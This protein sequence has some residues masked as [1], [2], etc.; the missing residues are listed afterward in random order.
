[1]LGT[2][3]TSKSSTLDSV[4][5][6]SLNPRA[7]GQ[8]Q[9]PP[10]GMEF[11]I[12]RSALVEASAARLGRLALPGRRPIDTPNFFAATS[13]GVVPHLTPDNLV[14]HDDLVR[15][16]Y[17]AF[18]DFIERSQR[19]PKRVPPLLQAAA[20]FPWPPPPP[21]SSSSSSQSQ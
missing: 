18:E 13:R 15:G 4:K 8:P 16:T 2:P 3:P 17:L 11:E 7:R 20:R 14:R 6:T 1:M 12:L 21:P 19:N 5:P 9:G 10:R